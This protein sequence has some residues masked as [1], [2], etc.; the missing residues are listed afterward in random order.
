MLTASII[1]PSYNREEALLGCLPAIGAEVVACNGELIVVDQT[2]YD[3]VRLSGAAG[4]ADLKHIRSKRPNLPA[5]RNVGCSVAR[6]DILVF[7]DDDA[8]PQPGWLRTHLAA[9]DNPAIGAIAGGV[10]DSNA[11]GE[12]PIP[13]KYDPINGSYSTDFGC[14]TRQETISVPGVNFSVRRAVWQ[15]T[16][17]D[18]SYVGNAYFEEVDFAFRLRRAGWAILYEPAARVVHEL[19]RAGGCR[20]T[21][22]TEAYYRFRNYALFYFRFSKVRHSPGFFLREKNYAE[23][24]SRAHRHGH[25]P[26]IVLA[27]IAGSLMGVLRGLA[28]KSRESVNR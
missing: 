4:G 14:T 18:E 6:G 23:Y 12:A 13:V 26:S 5:A 28:T 21:G 8:I 9:Y 17:F 25:R 16:L 2:G 22:M 7:I 27:A 3:K 11:K 20:Q 10:I 1:I 24:I 15:A 19:V